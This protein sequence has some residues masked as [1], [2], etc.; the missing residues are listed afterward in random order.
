M[1]DVLWRRLNYFLSPQLDIYKHLAPRLQGKRVLEV[2]FG[3][4]FGTLQLARYAEHIIAWE[5]DDDAIGFARTALPLSNVEWDYGDITVPQYH[6]EPEVVV[7]IEVLEHIEAY[8]LALN[9]VAAL[10]P[11]GGEFYMTARNANADLRHNN[12]HQRELTARELYIM[13][14]QYFNDV[15]FYDYEFREQDDNTHITPIVAVAVK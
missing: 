12:L 10:L 9:N 1:S 4:G 13:L 7:M 2:G 11:Y 15:M 3:T 8:Q 6:P 5:S 14:I